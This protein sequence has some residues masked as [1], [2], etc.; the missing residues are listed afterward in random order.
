MKKY[1]LIPFLVFFMAG[2]AQA[3]DSWLP[4]LQTET[5]EQGFD[6]AVKMA[7]MG[8]KT[9]Q[10]SMEVLKKGRKEYAD[11]AESLMMASQVIAIHFS[12]VAAANNYWK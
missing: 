3:E 6:L 2:F 1:L 9:T 7:R 4:S 5:P 11:D 8:V 12:T 10:P